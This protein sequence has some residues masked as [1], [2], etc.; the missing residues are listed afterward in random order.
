MGEKSQTDW[1]RA[2]LMADMTEKEAHSE[3]G[4][5]ERENRIG[6]I[7]TTDSRTLLH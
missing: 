1:G 4:E 3:R 6:G 7:D 5:I 2:W